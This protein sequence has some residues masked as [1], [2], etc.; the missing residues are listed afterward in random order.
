MPQTPPMS[1]AA[2]PSPPVFLES[3][4]P[5]A[6]ELVRTVTA[7]QANTFVL[8]GV[9]ADLVPVRGS[10]GLRFLSLDDFLS[11]QLFAGWP[12]IVTYNRAEGLGFANPAARNY[13]LACFMGSDGVPGSTN[14]CVPPDWQSPD[15]RPGCR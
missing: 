3:L 5:W 7:K 12:S 6:S 10:A 1:E 2:A 11:Q 4:P 15:L 14:G 9:P 13:V 8:H